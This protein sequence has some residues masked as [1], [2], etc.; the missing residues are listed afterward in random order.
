MEFAIFLFLPIKRG[1]QCWWAIKFDVILEWVVINF[2]N[3]YWKLAFCLWR[4]LLAYC[5]DKVD[6][7]VNLS[8]KQKQFR[9]VISA[10]TI[11]LRRSI[12]KADV[13]FFLINCF[14]FFFVVV[15]KEF[16]R[17][18][19]LSYQRK[20]EIV[21]SMHINEVKDSLVNQDG[22]FVKRA[23]VESNLESESIR[24]RR[25]SVFHFI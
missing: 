6:I 3:S 13:F 8:S 4:S 23:L 12:Y 19:L 14:R 16:L 5:W 21:Q 20:W 2:L 10:K 7:C 18:V 1:N 15:W 11:M 25:R 17:W 22:T 24:I 9:I